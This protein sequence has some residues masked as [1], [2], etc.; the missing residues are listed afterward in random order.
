MHDLFV[1]KR[2]KT[3]L[4]KQNSLVLPSSKTN[5]KGTIT[6]LYRSIS[7]WNSLPPKVTNSKTL[8]EF[9]TNLAAWTER[10]CICKICRV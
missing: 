3:I 7:L 6:T 1:I 2:P 8:Q 10:G 4:R 5:S 9:K